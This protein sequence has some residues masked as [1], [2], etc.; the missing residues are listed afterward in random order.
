VTRRSRTI[1][2]HLNHDSSGG[3]TR[4]T[5]SRTPSSAGRAI[6]RSESPTGGLRMPRLVDGGTPDG[7]E[8]PGGMAALASV[9]EADRAALAAVLG[10][11]TELPRFGEVDLSGLGVPDGGRFVAMYRAHCERIFRVARTVNIAEVK[12]TRVMHAVDVPA[13][14][15]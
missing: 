5:P 4:R 10:G 8:S 1:G 13:R 9:S 3:E 12:G 11:P 6:K 14:P 2:S 7:S 15:D